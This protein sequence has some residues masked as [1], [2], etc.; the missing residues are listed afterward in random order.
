MKK[1]AV[2]NT[3]PA[4]AW[5][6]PGERCFMSLCTER[7]AEE[8]KVECDACLSSLALPTTVFNASRAVIKIKRVMKAVI[9]ACAYLSRQRNVYNPYD[10][11]NIE[12]G[13]IRAPA[14]RAHR[15]LFSIGDKFMRLSPEVEISAEVLS[16]D[17][18]VRC[19]SMGP[20]KHVCT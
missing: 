20:G 9:S 19:K 4:Y 7:S 16:Q 14:T 3:S 13:T 12:N 18:H 8:T 5:Y 6:G 11:K 1:T 15:Q 17:S 2:H 10:K